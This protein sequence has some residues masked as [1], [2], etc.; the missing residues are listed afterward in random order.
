MTHD[1]AFGPGRASAPTS[2]RGP[3]SRGPCGRRRR[4]G[5]WRRPRGRGGRC[6]R[7]RG[8]EGVE[9]SLGSWGRPRM[10][11]PTP[12]LRARERPTR[13][14]LRWAQERQSRLSKPS[15]SCSLKRALSWRA[16]RI[17]SLRAKVWARRVARSASSRTRVR[18]VWR[19][20]KACSAA[21]R[22]RSRFAGAR[23]RGSRAGGAAAEQGA[24]EDEAQARGE[25]GGAG[26]GADDDDRRVGG[27]D[28]RPAVAD[29]DA[30]DHG[31]VG[32]ADA[33]RWRAGGRARSR[34]S[35]GGCPCRCRP[36]SRRRR[37]CLVWGARRR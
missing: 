15:S 25:L 37:R 14:P 21:D 5:W 18:R 6:H 26:G 31:G 9:R 32:E 12:R 34:P 17:G 36:R 23:G 20:W 30:G 7:R 35:T 11:R 19:G 22:T 10:S 2:G 33:L 8:L 4:P 27:A 16:R 29:L 24:A 3:R 13:W 28:L 1:L